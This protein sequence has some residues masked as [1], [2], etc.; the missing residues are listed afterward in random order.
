[1]T[2]GAG[3]QAEIDKHEENGRTP[4]AYLY[5]PDL[6]PGADEWLG[7]FWEMSTDRRFSGGPI[8]AESIDRWPVHPDEADTF[9]RCIRAMDEAFRDHFAKP[10][11][12]TPKLTPQMFSEMVRK[13]K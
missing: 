7:A 9:R 6:L 12:E 1:L 11:E 13:R 5:P 4:P 10:K 8:P 3:A 2:H